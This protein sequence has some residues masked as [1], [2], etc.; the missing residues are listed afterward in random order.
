M[1]LSLLFFQRRAFDLAR[2]GLGT[3]SPN[4]CVGSVIINNQNQLIIGEGWH[5]KYGQPHAEVNAIASVPALQKVTLPHSTIFVTLEP[6]FH[7]G[8][9]PPCVDLILKKEISNV[10]IAFTDSNPKVAGKSITKLLLNNVNVTLNNENTISVDNGYLFTLKPFFTN[11][12]KQRPYI[13]LKW[14]ESADNFIGLQN[15]QIQISNNFSKRLVH[16]WRSECDAILVGTNTALTDN[17]ALNNRFYFG[18]SPLRIIIDK[19]N[20]LSKGLKIFDKTIPTWIYTENVNDETNNS[21]NLVFKNIPF[22]E[23]FLQNML[24]DMLKNKI[25]IVLIEGGTKILQSFIDAGLWDEARV[26]KNTQLFL[27]QNEC[28]VPSPILKDSFSHSSQP[29]DDNVVSIYLKNN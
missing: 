12:N 22:D 20:K 16:K 14:A 21:E 13:I 27:G 11:I 24:S 23:S 7:F 8:Q 15:K 4:P 28:P 9:T 6:C 19:K 1:N 2:L 26:I 5:K 3:A 29:L 25:G 18:K 17:P 10:V